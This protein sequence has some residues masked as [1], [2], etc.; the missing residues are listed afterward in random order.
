MTEESILAAITRSNLY[1]LCE[2]Y[3]LDAAQIDSSLAHLEL[4]KGTMSP[5]APYLLLHYRPKGQSP[6]FV[7][8]YQVDCPPGRQILQGALSMVRHEVHKKALANSRLILSVEL[9]QEQL[10][11]MGLL[12]GYEIARWAAEAGQGLVWALDGRWYRL[13][14]H[15]AFMP[16]DESVT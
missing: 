5:F 10:R 4:V 12:W 8:A 3:G 15:Q 13:N 11:D 6:V 1:T 2:Q 16:F 9:S 7:F 14:A